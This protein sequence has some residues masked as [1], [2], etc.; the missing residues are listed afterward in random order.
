MTPGVV[1]LRCPACARPFLSLPQHSETLVACPHCART[2]VAGAFPPAGATP[3]PV[4]QSLRQRGMQPPAVELPAQSWPSAQPLYTEPPPPVAAPQWPSFPPETYPPASPFSQLD[5]YYD[6]S[7]PL[8]VLPSRPYGE[9]YDPF[10][11]RHSERNLP[12]GILFVMA[13]AFGG[14]LLW[15]NLQPPLAFDIPAAN[16]PADTPPIELSLT[17]EPP[18]SPDPVIRRAVVTPPITAPE[19]PAVDLA[20]AGQMAPK[21]LNALFAASSGTEREPL[22]ADAEQHREAMAQF[23]AGPPLEVIS[24]IP[25]KVT[26]QLQAGQ[27]IAPLFQVTTNANR[28]GALLRLVPQP[29]GGF[30]LDWPIF[31]E[32]HQ[33]LLGRF[34][35]EK[36][37]EPTW[38]Y[39][40]LKRSQPL[41]LP[42]ALRSRHFCFDLQASVDDSVRFYAGAEKESPVG[43]FLD[44]DTEWGTVYVTRLL[45]QWRGL[46]APEETVA[47]LDCEGSTNAPSAAR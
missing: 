6:T 33:R 19:P 24:I 29:D 1:S 18:P 42:S 17:L 43:R 28:H 40:C 22:V 2:A 38:F 15:D 7:A 13:L 45:L 9:I 11:P 44:R 16:Q 34:L 35:A 41:E 3:D 8:P 30:L 37:T 14:W 46:N 5:T 25:S 36:P 31:A 12:L 32:T 23:F 21:L 20:V 10:P 27:A 4:A 47:I 26:P 39:V